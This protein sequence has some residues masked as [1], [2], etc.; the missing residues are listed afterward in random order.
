MGTRS[1][2]LLLVLLLGLGETLNG[3]SSDSSVLFINWMRFDLLGFPSPSRNLLRLVCLIS[4]RTLGIPPA[5]WRRNFG[6][7][8]RSLFHF[9]FR[10]LGLMEKP[11]GCGESGDRGD[12]A[13]T[14]EPERESLS[15]V[16]GSGGGLVTR[17]SSSRGLRFGSW[18]PMACVNWPRGE[19]DK[20]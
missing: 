10:K 8:I 4:L 18:A 12:L 17:L 5:I 1:S 9:D 20:S 7:N 19:G 16:A 14:G 6:K 3:G 11:R 15:G 2:S 13:I